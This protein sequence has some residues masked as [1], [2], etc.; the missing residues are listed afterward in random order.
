MLYIS[1]TNLESSAIEFVDSNEKV[2]I[3]S[4]YIKLDEIKKINRSKNVKRIIV[5]WEILDLCKEV[6]DLEVYDYCQENQIALFRNTRLH[7]KVMWN[8]NGSVLFGSAN[9]TN[10]GIGEN[11]RFNYELNGLKEKIE[12]NTIK[13]FNQILKESQYL[14]DSLYSKIA[15]QVE[16]IGKIE[17]PQEPYIIKSLEEKLQNKFLLSDLPMS[18]TVDNLYNTYSRLENSTN[19]ELLYAAHDLALYELPDSLDRNNFDQLLGLKFNSH[20]FIIAL[21]QNIAEEQSMRY[22]SV[23]RW[24]QTNTTTVPTPRSWELKKELIVNILYD[25][26][27]H[28][29]KNFTYSKPRHSEVI[30]YIGNEEHE[31]K[32]EKSGIANFIRRLKRDKARGKIAPHQIILLLSLYRI[33]NENREIKISIDELKYKFEKAWN[34]NIEPHS[35]NNPN[36]VMPIKAFYRRNYISLIPRT[37]DILS[38]RNYSDLNSIYKYIKLE[39]PLIS[40]IPLKN[41]EEIVYKHI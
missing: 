10:K 40:L 13:Y 11:G 29:D 2:T 38:I 4:A 1:G 19:E 3:F 35:S 7:M 22:G 32:N 20:P 5:R 41:F 28:F 8:D 34:E 21:K 37:E 17:E 24:I 15:A 14:N 16:K 25:W 31:F 12:F 18:R 27:C 30:F 39:E 9:I 36:I 6:S 33:Y 23:L 26:I